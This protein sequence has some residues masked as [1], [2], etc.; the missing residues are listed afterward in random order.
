M[1]M[2]KD[3]ASLSI[4]VISSLSEIKEK[5]WDKC[6]DN[7]HPFTRYAFL[8]TLEDSGSAIK[9]TGWLPQHLVI[10]EK[11]GTILAV[12]P[13]YLKNHSYGEYVFDWG[14]ADAYHR[15]GGNYYPKLQCSVPFTPVTGPRLMT[16]SDLNDSQRK[17]LR[18]MLMSGMLDLTEKL[19]ISSIH[20]TFPTT[21]E[22]IELGEGGFLQRTNQQFH[23]EN[24]GFRDFDEFL[25]TLN[26]R[27]RKAIKKERKNVANMNF[28]IKV[29]S[30]SQIKDYHWDAFFE[31]YIL[32]TDK[33]FGQSYLEKQFFPMLGKRMGNQAVLILVQDGDKFVAGALN[34]KDKDT[35]YG[36]NW[37]CIG[38]HK[39]L[40]F[41]TC[42][43]QAID[44][45]I[46]NDL[47]YVEAG[48]QGMHKIQ[49]GYLPT[50]TY[51]AHW[52]ADQRL[53]NALDTFLEQEGKA[54]KNE[55]DELLKFSPYR[56][57]SN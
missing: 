45:A 28:T 55:I 39:F 4:K 35:L 29:L 53:R 9:E 18:S 13:L 57:E 23:W 27:K 11:S 37:G 7:E 30:G 3:E 14:W 34:L 42:Y 15:A 6:N 22:W 44:F 41:E 17:T 8:K 56:K 50:P 2:I 32:T 52:V 47:K 51:S 24:R 20:I 33:K 38:T 54:V 5:D 21:K 40:H 48:A 25:Q 49:R 36:R 43:Y 1:L 12:A 31:F 19:G 10:E 46:A 26:S 16:R